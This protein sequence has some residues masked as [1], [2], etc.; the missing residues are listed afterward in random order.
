MKL[1]YPNLGFL[2]TKWWSGKTGPSKLPYNDKTAQAE[3]QCKAE[4]YCQHH[5]RLSHIF[6]ISQLPTSRQNPSYFPISYLGF[7]PCTL[8]FL[9][10][11]LAEALIFNSCIIKCHEKLIKDAK[12]VIS[13]SS[14]DVLSEQVQDLGKLKTGKEC[15]WSHIPITESVYGGKI[16]EFSAEPLCLHQG[17]ATEWLLFIT[18]VNVLHFWY[19]C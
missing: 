3:F 18:V 16:P 7:H 12:K 14:F 9:F 11:Q 8:F 5:D 15:F 17:I 13:F 19:Y 2:L 10:F 4:H 6:I 1:H